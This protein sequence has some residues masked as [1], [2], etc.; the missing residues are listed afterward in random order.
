M[1]CARTFFIGFRILQNNKT[2]KHKLPFPPYADSFR[3]LQ[4]NKT[5]KHVTL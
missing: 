3:I 1:T 5:L 2:L 4:N